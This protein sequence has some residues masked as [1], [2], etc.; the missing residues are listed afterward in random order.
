[1][2]RYLTGSFTPAQRQLIL[3]AAVLL[4]PV[5]FLPMLPIWHMYMVAPQYPEG[6]NLHIYT[7]TIRGDLDKINILNHYVGMKKIT[8]SDF[9]E[10][11]YM[12]QALTL[13]G[14]AALLAVL[15]ARRWVAIVGWLAFTGFAVVMFN[16]YVQWLYHYGHDLDPRAAIK[17]QAFMP[18]VIGYN[19]M[20]NFRVWSFPGI[21]TWLLGIAW[22]LGPAILW[23][24][25]RTPTAGDEPAAKAAKATDAA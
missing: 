13:F 12:P 25:R 17:L 21:G 9:A 19:R 20:A 24:E 16:D 2:T 6:L 11:A 1:M 8:P 23:L 15:F 5:F 7:N 3:V 10:F 18:P 4:L 22:L 14:V